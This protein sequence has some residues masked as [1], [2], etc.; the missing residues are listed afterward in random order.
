MVQSEEK[1]GRTDLDLSN[2]GIVDSNPTGV[3][4]EFLLFSC[5][6]IS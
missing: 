5:V 3:I 4:D 2:T 1:F 6:R